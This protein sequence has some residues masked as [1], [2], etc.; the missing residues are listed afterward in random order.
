VLTGLE[1]LEDEIAAAAGEGDEELQ[2]QVEQEGRKL[3][4]KQ[5]RR[6]Y[7]LKNLILSKVQGS[8]CGW[9]AVCCYVKVRGWPC[10]ALLSAFH[11]G[12]TNTF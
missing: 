7:Y 10:L 3:S 8:G 5:N 9:G 6:F 4:Q 11:T 1:A 12:L 2:Q